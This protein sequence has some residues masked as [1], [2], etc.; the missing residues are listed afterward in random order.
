MLK[1]S[2]L[3]LGALSLVRD[4]ITKGLK[5]NVNITGFIDTDLGRV[6]VNFNKQVGV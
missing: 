4:I 1:A 3:T 6:N 2:F 5:F